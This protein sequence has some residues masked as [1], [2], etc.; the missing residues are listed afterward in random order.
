MTVLSLSA[1][2]VRRQR[3]ALST[4]Q[5]EQLYAAAAQYWRTVYK[6]SEPEIRCALEHFKA[7]CPLAECALRAQLVGA[8]LAREGV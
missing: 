5:P 3:R 6:L 4:A 7:D 1:Y 8:A 2:R